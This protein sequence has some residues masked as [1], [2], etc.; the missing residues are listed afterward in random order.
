MLNQEKQ[1]KNK[2]PGKSDLSNIGNQRDSTLSVIFSEKNIITN[3]EISNIHN[4]GWIAFEGKM[5]KINFYENEA[6]LNLLDYLKLQRV[7]H[8]SFMSELTVIRHLI[9]TISTDL[10][11]LPEQVNG[12]INLEHGN[13]NTDRI[14]D[15]ILK[16]EFLN[17]WKK[18]IDFNP[19]L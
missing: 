13:K 7:L 14:L 18:L 15:S 2:N 5:V 19:N 17:H 3:D 6:V 16:N 12:E 10:M 1:I 8:C 11:M 4:N 9:K